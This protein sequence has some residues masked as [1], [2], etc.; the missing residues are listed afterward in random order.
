MGKYGKDIASSSS[1]IGQKN[2]HFFQVFTPDKSSHHL[3]L[4]AA[5]INRLDEDLPKKVTLRDST[6]KLWS[7]KVVKSGND[8]FFQNGWGDFVN[9]YTLQYGNFLMFN[10]HG[11]SR[12][13]VSVFDYSTQCERED[14]TIDYVIGNENPSL[15]EDACELEVPESLRQSLGDS[16]EN[17]SEKYDVIANSYDNPEKPQFTAT[18]NDKSQY[19]VTDMTI[20]VQ[21]GKKWPVEVYCE[22]YGKRYVIRKGWHDFRT[23]NNMKHGDK[24]ILEFKK[25]RGGRRTSDVI[26]AY[27][28]NVKLER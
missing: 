14:T 13:H 9:H 10:Y 21:S 12:F 23:E 5:F 22:E 2:H 27:P 20:R 3:K 18:V 19:A 16:S 6:D 24:C 26:H 17:N 1:V 8:Y 28:L 25:G 4:P 7:V 11:N 15:G